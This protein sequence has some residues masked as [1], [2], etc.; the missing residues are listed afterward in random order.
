MPQPADQPSV[1]LLGAVQYAGLGEETEVSITWVNNDSTFEVGGF[2]ILLAYDTLALSFLSA[3]PGQLLVDCD[4]EYFTY[5]Y[6]PFGNCGNQCPSGLLRVVAIAE[7]NNGANHPTCLTLDPKPIVLFSLD[8]LVSNDRTL[9]CMYVPIRFFWM[10]CGDNSIAFHPAD[11][12]DGYTT[13]QGVSRYVLTMDMYHIENMNV[14][15]GFPTYTGVQAECFD[16]DPEKPLPIQFVDF[17]N[18]GV[19][20][21]CA[22]SIDARGD[23]N[24]NGNSNEIADAVLFS[25]YFVKGLVVFN[26][27]VQGQIAA[28]DVNADGLTLSVADLV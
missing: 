11:D 8:F 27:N 17:I 4:W 5:R 28:S 20:I 22:D 14:P 9:E 21:I 15:G 16:N 6:G 26:V 12:P 19:D 23:I 25:N 13:V 24:L 7:T 1:M 3:E 10:D 18:G 2:D